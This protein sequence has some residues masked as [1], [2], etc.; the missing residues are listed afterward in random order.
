[1]RDEDTTVEEWRPV[2][3]HEL[4]YMVSNLGRFWSIER[5]DTVGRLMPGRILKGRVVPAGY[6]VYTLTAIHGHRAVLESFVGPCPPGMFGCHNDGDPSNNRLENLRWDTP[7]ANSQ[8]M[9]KHGH[10]TRGVK[11][12]TTK[13]SESEVLEIRARA[14]AGERHRDIAE[15]FGVG[16]TTVTSIACRRNWGWL[17]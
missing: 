5:C 13:L 9:V 16:R 12:N 14:D 7:K 15:C 11:N 4:K 2:A 1:M 17:D 8:D 6:T 3:G 10:S